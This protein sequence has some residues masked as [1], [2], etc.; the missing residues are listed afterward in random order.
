MGARAS[1][2]EGP[3]LP[4]LSM[5]Q[6]H[7]ALERPPPTQWMRLILFK[8][9]AREVG[10]VLRPVEFKGQVTNDMMDRGEQLAWRTWDCVNQ[11]LLAYARRYAGSAGSGKQHARGGQRN[12]RRQLCVQKR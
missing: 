3:A 7:K 5:P 9:R 4:P 8:L 11:S 6:L 1:V 10:E 12:L 2:K